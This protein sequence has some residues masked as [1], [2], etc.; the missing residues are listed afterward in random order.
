M[1]EE[2]DLSSND[3]QARDSTAAGINPGLTEPPPKR[4][5]AQDDFRTKFKTEMCK[6]FLDTGECAYSARVCFFSDFIF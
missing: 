2:A 5:A 6:N 4:P 1:T 3:S